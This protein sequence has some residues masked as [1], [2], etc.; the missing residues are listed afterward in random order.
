MSH[1]KIKI[2]EVKLVP[3]SH[4]SHALVYDVVGVFGFCIFSNFYDI[5]LLNPWIV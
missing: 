5:F 2:S 1:S 4:T 3:F